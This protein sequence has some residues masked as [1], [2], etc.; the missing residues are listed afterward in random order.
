MLESERLDP[1]VVRKLRDPAVVVV[2]RPGRPPAA[3]ICFIPGRWNNVRTWTRDD[4]GR[5]F[6]VGLAQRG[7]AVGAVPFRTSR[8]QMD[9]A[10]LADCRTTDLLDD[11]DQAL[12]V[13]RRAFPELPV[14]LAGYSLGASLACLAASRDA[15]LNGLILLDGGIAPSGSAQPLASRHDLVRSPSW[16]PRFRRQAEESLADSRNGWESVASPLIT[17]LARDFDQLRYLMFGND[18]WW[19]SRQIE[20]IANLAES[21]ACGEILGGIRIPVLGVRSKDSSSG[22]RCAATIQAMVESPS[23]TVHTLPA[24]WTHIDVVSHPEV[25]A[26]WDQIA[27]WIEGVVLR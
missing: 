1:L 7:F 20:E 23:R 13:T 24:D 2:P 27:E 19:P 4:V 10:N 9:L 26:Q 17:S 25:H 11:I 6:R 15:G 12:L 14:I 22:T 16:N 18:E 8:L 21:E 3:V 5:D